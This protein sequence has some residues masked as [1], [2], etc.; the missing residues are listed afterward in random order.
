V[1]PDGKSVKLTDDA[2]RE[3]YREGFDK[4]VLMQTGQVYKISLT[5]MATAIRLEKGHQIRLDI[6]SSSFPW[7]ERNL[8]T[9]GNNYDE[10]HWLV[11]ENGIHYGGQYPSHV[12]LL[13]LPE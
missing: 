7:Y 4:K 5:N 11:A 9:G 3:R 6:S 12:V 8:N 13:V 1:Y 2:F 10:S